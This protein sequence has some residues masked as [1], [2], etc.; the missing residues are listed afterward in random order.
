MAKKAKT[1]LDNVIDLALEPEDHL[2]PLLNFLLVGLVLNLQLLIVHE[3]D[4]VCLLVV[5]LERRLAKRRIKKKDK[6]DE[7]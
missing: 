4:T 6:A 1:D 5:F 2:V 3:V 7:K